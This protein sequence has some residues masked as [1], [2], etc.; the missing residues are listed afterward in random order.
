MVNTHKCAETWPALLFNWPGLVEDRRNC[1]YWNHEQNAK[2]LRNSDR[3]WG[4]NEQMTFW[5]GTLLQAWLNADSNNLVHTNLNRVSSFIG[6]LKGSQSPAIISYGC[7]E[8]SLSM[9]EKRELKI[10]HQRQRNVLEESPQ[11]KWLNN[12]QSH[13]RNKLVGN[14]PK[15]QNPNSFEWHRNQFHFLPRYVRLKGKMMMEISNENNTEMLRR[16]SSISE[17]SRPSVCYNFK[18]FASF[19]ANCKDS[20]SEPVWS[21]KQHSECYNMPSENACSWIN[22]GFYCKSKAKDRGQNESGW[23]TKATGILERST[24]LRRSVMQAPDLRLISPLHGE[25]ILSTMSAAHFGR[26]AN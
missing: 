12:H 17:E 6:Q 26:N 4:E 8:E 11:A 5:V 2:C 1:R 13:H 19:D 21:N 24:E 25:T 9:G 16:S 3:I 23:K 18:E 15:Y 10:L 14:C 7:L 20:F 22:I